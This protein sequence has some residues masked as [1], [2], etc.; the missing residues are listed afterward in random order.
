MRQS[1][2]DPDHRT[3]LLRALEAAGKVQSTIDPPELARVPKGYATADWDHLLR[4][5]NLIVRTQGNLPPPDWLFTPEAPEE[6][7]SI[8]RAHLPLLGW[9]V[10]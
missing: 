1:I 9:L 6:L 2:C 3:D 5:K 7:A 4:R 10:G 8:A